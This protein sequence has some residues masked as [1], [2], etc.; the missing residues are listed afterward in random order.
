MK[1]AI[2]LLGIAILCSAA[3]TACHKDLDI[4][5]DNALSASNMWKDASD[6][7]QSVPGIYKRLHS[8]FSAN[9][10]NVFYF[11][12]T[13]VGDYM[14]GPSLESKVQDN[15]KIACRHNT[16]NPSN[17]IGWSG[18]YSTIDQANAVIKHAPECNATQARLDWALAQAYFARA[19]CYFN[20]ARIWGEVPV[21]LLPVESTTQ[22]ECYPSQKSVA[23]VLAQ[24]EKDITACEALA[25][26]LGNEKYFATKDALNTLKADYALW[27]YRVQNGGAT[28]L[29]MA[30][31]A[32]KAI[33]ISSSKLL[34]DYGKIFDRTNKKNSEIIFS[35]ALNASDTGGYQIYFCHP[36]NLIAAS[37]RNNPVPISSTQWWSYSKGFVDELKASEAKGD[38]RVATNLGYGPYSSAADKHEITWCNKLVGDKS[39]SPV[40]QDN[41]LIYYRYGYVVMMD[42]ELK[43]YKKDYAGANA[44]LNLIAKR[45]YGKT[46]YY[47]STAEADVLNN[48]IH[49]Y[50]MEFPAEGMIWWA[51]IRTGKIWTME[52]NSEIPGQ[53]FQDMKAKNPNILLWPIAQGSINKNSNLHQIEGWQ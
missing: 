39:K 46:D 53:T 49:E 19:Y 40:V 42:A 52:P 12:E 43:Y 16:L 45:A 37:Y 22:E 20:A 27:M 3:F 38:K 51:L 28:Y 13:R 10:C 24:V 4:P 6:L 44:S 32:L 41:D 33:G 26:S 30:E 34:T 23:E 21:N 18:L 35:L 47:T 9:E 8:Y 36:S 48:I 5:Y 15:F 50:F 11:G 7:E 29:T 1:N 17:T 14:W 25:E 31:T 2:K